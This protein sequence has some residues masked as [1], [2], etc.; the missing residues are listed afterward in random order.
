MTRPVVRCCLS[1]TAHR[2]QSAVQCHRLFPSIR[3]QV[4]W[5]HGPSWLLCNNTT[6]SLRR[7]RRMSSET[8]F[9]IEVKTVSTSWVSRAVMS[10][11]SGFFLPRLVYREVSMR[12]G[13]RVHDYVVVEQFRSVNV[14][15]NTDSRSH[16]SPMHSCMFPWLSVLWSCV[17]VGSAAVRGLLGSLS[18]QDLG[19]TGVQVMWFH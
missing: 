11:Q 8:V 9:L 5:L 16:W 18:L 17:A 19:F 12:G 14:E 10:C 15:A 1:K 13:C 7:I 3:I 2:P 4:V 6:G